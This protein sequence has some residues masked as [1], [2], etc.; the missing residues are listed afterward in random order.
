MGMNF[1]EMN[2]SEGVTKN[3][4]PTMSDLGAK[5]GNLSPFSGYFRVS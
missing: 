3:E 1:G 2:S 5:K 4:N